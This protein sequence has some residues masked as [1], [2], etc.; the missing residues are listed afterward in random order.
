MPDAP[1]LACFR[2]LLTGLTL[3]L[4]QAIRRERLGTRPYRVRK[5]RLTRVYCTGVPFDGE[6]LSLKPLSVFVACQTVFVV[7]DPK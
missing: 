6:P 3:W 2:K 7:F 1:A 5:A 4:C